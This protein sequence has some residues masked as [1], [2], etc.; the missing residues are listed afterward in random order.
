MEEAGHKCEVLPVPSSV[1]ICSMQSSA[2][3]YLE[4]YWNGEMFEHTDQLEQFADNKLL[5]NSVQK[6]II[7][8]FNK[9]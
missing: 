8:F 2:R 3:R 4:Y 1:D 5:E 9:N 7:Y 6:E